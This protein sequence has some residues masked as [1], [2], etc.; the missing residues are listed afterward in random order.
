MMARVKSKDTKPEMMLRKTLHRMG[1]RYR[2][3]CKDI[4]GKPDLTIAKYRL[5][6]FVDGDLW[7]GNEHKLRGLDTIESLFPT[8]TTFWSDKIR[9]NM[10]RDAAVNARLSSEGWVVLRL[11]ASEIATDPDAAAGRVVDLLQRLKTK[12][13]PLSA[14]K[15][16][17]S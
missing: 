9:G 16:E 10:A 14:N 7:H 2:V 6:V 1:I 15:D 3:H 4:F 12:G 5:A 8:N 17:A 11:W 13:R